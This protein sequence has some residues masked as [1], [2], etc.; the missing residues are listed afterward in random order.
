MGCILSTIISVVQAL[1]E[2]NICS[3]ME[4]VD[5]C[6][7]AVLLLRCW[8][9]DCDDVKSLQQ[10]VEIISLCCCC[11]GHASLFRWKIAR[12]SSC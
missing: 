2:V 11:Y 10:Y 9:V 1:T 7:F 6:F 3:V 4:P 5:I 12:S 8:R